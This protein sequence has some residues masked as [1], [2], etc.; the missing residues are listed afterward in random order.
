MASWANWVAGM[1]YWSRGLGPAVAN[2]L[3][4]ST[5]FALAAW[6]L[7]LALRGNHARV[8]HAV[9]LAASVKFLVPFSLLIAAGN[10]LPHPKQAVAPVVYSAMDAVEEPFDVVAP[11]EEIPTH[12]AMRPRH[13]W[14]TLLPDGL[15]VVWLLGACAA[16]AVWGSRWRAVRRVLRRA[17]AACEGREWEILRRV[18]T[19]FA[20]REKANHREQRTQ[21][22][23]L[24]E[25]AQGESMVPRAEARCYSDRGGLELRLSAERM[26]PGIFGV[27]RPVLV[28]PRELSARLDDAHI[29]AIL[30]HELMHVRRR[31]NLTAALHML[32]EA[33]FW[34][35]PAV[36]WMERQMVKEREQA[37]DEAVLE[38]GGNAPD[39]AQTY[40]ESLLKTCRFCIESPLACV[41]GVTGADLKQRVVEIVT[42][43]ALLRMTWPKKLLLA[44]A[45]VCV[46]AAPVVLGQAKAAQRMMLAV[47]K[48]APKPVQMAARALI[49]LEETPGTELI[50]EQQ[51]S[52]SV[53]VGTTSARPEFVVSTVRPSN[54]ATADSSGIYTG[55]G[56]LNGQNVT[57]MRAI[58]GAY[59]VGP[60]QVVGGPDW[61]N[62]LRWDIQAK[63]DQDINDDATLNAMQA[64]L[65][66][67]RFKLV[68]HKETRTMPAYVLEVG[69]NGPKLTKAEGG[70]DSDTEMRT[71]TVGKEAMKV[72][73]TNMDLFAAILA[74]RMD[75]PVVNET[76]LKGIY[77]FDL[78]WTRDNTSAANGPDALSIFTAVQEQLGL[79]LRAAKAPVE[80]L[81]IDH[82]EKPTL[83]GAEVSPAASVVPAAMAQ[84]KSQ[85]EAAPAALLTFE[86][87]S[88]RVAKNSNPRALWGNVQMLPGG[89]VMATQVPLPILISAA[90]DLPFQS[91]RISFAPGV[92]P[93]ADNYD[94]EAVGPAGEFPPGISI[95]ARDAKIRLMLQSLLADRFHLKLRVE[96]KEQPAYVLVVDKGGPK[97]TKSKMTLHDC[98][99]DEGCHEAGGGQGRGIHGNAVSIGDVALFVQ[100]WTDKPVVDETG[101]KGLYNIQTEGWLPMRMRPPNPDGS[102]PSGGDTGLN[103]PDRQTLFQVFEQLGLR[104]ES[105]RAVVD[106][107]VVES[108]EK[109]SEN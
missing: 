50:G 92:K 29:E 36:W 107:Y 11:P 20:V 96:P 18:G 105:K 90:Y 34:F 4:Q 94:I 14:G 21:S 72:I 1:T 100:N 46:V 15:A 8:R 74:R 32:V 63:A 9:W 61:V 47:A 56:R 65:L 43:R 23:A 102:A 19:R 75:L 80:V 10:L 25:A 52:Q 41:A 44:V 59:G 62:T 81:V 85:A 98:E 13:E 84:E 30:A 71:S 53:S 64:D 7:T 73:N 26:E 86:A 93:P 104:M 17:E 68:L 39:Y 33:V 22:G 60:N 99:T 87:A 97:L 67:D 78:N 103:E 51:G 82:A 16:L 79:R 37:C 91:A 12:A 2:H 101:L 49:P 42:G 58:I 31:D 27:W 66:V 48:I 45:A 83:D 76:G 24:A 106:M 5:A 54:A 109:P 3:W 38:M 55:H 40:A 28:W 35:H 70:G 95:E 77:N 57:L 6:L 108:V 69:K 88:I 89:R